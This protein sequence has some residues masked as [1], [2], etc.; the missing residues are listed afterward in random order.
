MKKISITEHH[1][2]LKT[3]DKI[4][5]AARKKKGLYRGTKIRMTPDLSL[6]TMHQVLYR[7]Q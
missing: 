4:L 2:L 5:K 7:I 6:Q 1:K 3:K